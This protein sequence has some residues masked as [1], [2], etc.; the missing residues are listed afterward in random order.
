MKQQLLYLRMPH[1][2][3]TPICTTICSG[4]SSA[5]QWSNVWEKKKLLHYHLFGVKESTLK[6]LEYDEFNK[7]STK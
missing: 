3:W 6:P 7:I 5:L 4:A 2:Y 1:Q